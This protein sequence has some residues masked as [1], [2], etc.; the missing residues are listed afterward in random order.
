M[1]SLLHELAHGIWAIR[2]EVA[3]HFGPRIH[4]V[5]A[6]KS[7][8]A[9]TMQDAEQMEEA[10]VRF[11]AR[12]GAEQRVTRNSTIEPMEGMVVV[13]DISG[14]IMKSAFCGPSMLSMARWLAEYDRTP[15][16]TGVVLNIDSGGGNGYGMLTL[17]DQIEKMNK[18]VVSITQQGMACSAAYGIG[19]ACDLFYS[20][21][22]VDEFGSIGTY[23]RV[24]DYSGFY[25]KEGI[26]FHTIKA[27]RSTAKNRDI[28]QAMKGN[29]EDQADKNY[30]ALRKNYIDPFNEHFIAMV[31]RNRPGVKDEHEVLA[32]RVFFAQEALK[33]GLIDKTKE[34]LDGAIAAVRQL[35]KTA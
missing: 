10:N 28:E 18:P 9:S 16:V 13:M 20:A 32:G 25:A 29:P 27:T 33:Y 26:K 24:P 14:P 21:S 6:G 34:T 5:F 1:K 11:V 19:A 12:D 31:Q 35:A 7:M 4:D 8:Q 22:E 17:T 30:E 23:V 3:E 15:E 2:P